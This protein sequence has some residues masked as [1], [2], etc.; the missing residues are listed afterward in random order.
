MNTWVPLK[1]HRPRGS[2][3][4]GES[5]RARIELKHL[6]CLEL[7]T[8]VQ[9][10]INYI[11]NDEGAIDQCGVNVKAGG[12]MTVGAWGGVG[13]GR[14]SGTSPLKQIVTISASIYN[15]FH[16]VIYNSVVTT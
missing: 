16:S 2:V 3:N 1:M 12:E 13:S 6:S 11:Q 5:R 8:M 9:R 15:V 4:V 7:M 14:G 10:L